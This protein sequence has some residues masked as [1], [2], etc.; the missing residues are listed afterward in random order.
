[1]NKYVKLDKNNNN[2]NNS[3]IFLTKLKY[4]LCLQIK[5]DDED[6]YGGF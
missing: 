3:R 6:I 2:N 4:Y 5:E 1:M